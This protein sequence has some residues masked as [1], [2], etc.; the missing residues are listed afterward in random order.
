MTDK[1]L[2]KR[3]KKLAIAL[4]L[5]VICMIILLGY[6]LGSQKAEL[7]LYTNSGYVDNL[8]SLGLKEEEFKQYLALFGYLADSEYSEKE[9]MLNMATN[10][11]EVM[12]PSYEPQTDANGLKSYD[13]DGIKEIVKEVKG[14]SGKED[15]E[16]GQ[17][18]IYEKESN[19]FKQKQ[20]MDC[21]MDCQEIKEITKNGEE[22]EVIYTFYAMTKEQMAEF[23]TGQSQEEYTIHT[24]KAVIVPNAE[25]EYS[26]Y[27]V[28]EIKEI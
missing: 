1:E 18:Y 4:I 17:Y 14:M 21:L 13:A 12:C 8:Q 10:F 20:P 19:Q 7:S 6:T 24:A 27:F 2:K 28:R 5:V 11:M 9:K 15:L 16:E 22:I 3:L 25:Y 26:K 23:R